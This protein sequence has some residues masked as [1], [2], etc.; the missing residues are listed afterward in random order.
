MKKLLLFFILILVGNNLSKA[1]SSLTAGDIAFLGYNAD[2]DQNF[3]F[4]LLTDIQNGTAIKFTDNGWLNNVDVGF[5]TDSDD[6]VITWTAN[7]ALVA[8]TIVFIQ[9]MTTTEG[10]ITS[11]TGLDLDRFGDQVLAYQ[12]TDD[13]NA[14]F[15]SAI[16]MNSTSSTNSEN[17]DNTTALSDEALSNLP[18]GLTTGVNAII[19][20]DTGGGPAERDNAIYNCINTNI[21]DVNAIR[22]SINDVNNWNLDNFT[23]FVLDPFPCSFVVLP[24]PDINNFSVTNT[25]ATTTEFTWDVVIEATNGYLVEVY[26]TGEDPNT[27]TP[28]F[29]DNVAAGNTTS[30]VSGLMQYNFYDVYIVAD[31]GTANGNSKIEMLTFESTTCP[32]V[33][34]LFLNNVA[35]TTAAVGWI[36]VPEATE[37]Y[38]IEIFLTGQDP[39]VDTPLIIEMGA[40]NTGGRFITGLTPATTYDAYVTTD[41]GAN[42]LGATEV[43]TFTTTTSCPSVSNLNGDSITEASINLFWDDV[44]EATN[45][46]TIEVYNDGENPDTSTPIITDSAPFGA[47]NIVITGLMAD[48]RYDAYVTV[49]C[50]AA[51]GNSLSEGINFRAA[52]NPFICGNTFLDPGGQFEDYPEIFFGEVTIS[53]DNAGDAVTLTFT[54]VDIGLVANSNPQI[55]GGCRDWLRIHDGPDTSA[56]ILKEFLCGEASGDGDVPTDPNAVLNIGDSFTSTHPTGTLTFVFT[57]NFGA[58]ES[59]WEADITCNT[60]LSVNEFNTESFSMAPNPTNG[61]VS[62]KSKQYIDILEVYSILGEKVLE[63]NPN[64]RIFDIDLTHLQAGIYII[65][66]TDGK[67]IA[68][69]KLIKN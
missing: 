65:K 22:A 24:C 49:I 16:H 6:S 31:C 54:Y 17:W 27:T 4:I 39:M 37:G 68:T 60:T 62:F 23:P 15:I 30:T 28:L 38:Q 18:N 66:S 7:S 53:P 20:F 58:I 12:G 46:F 48:F 1:Q 42:G 35:E 64:S 61:V 29:I 47:T 55:T 67:R 34:D 63:I 21:N 59:G 3:A 43:F 36:I 11:G 32:R 8:G 19:V 13:I 40:A 56:P 52:S 50:N 33:P 25:T 69:N 51:I 57:S 45:G 14:N 26:N 10:S 9:G 2:G 41:C 5:L 44:P